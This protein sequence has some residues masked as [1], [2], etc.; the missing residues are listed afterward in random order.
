MRNEEMKSEQKIFSPQILNVYRALTKLGSYAL[1]DTVPI[2]I[3]VFKEPNTLMN[4]ID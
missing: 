3:M 2:S 4:H 1:H